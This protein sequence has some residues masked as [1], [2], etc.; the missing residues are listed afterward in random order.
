MQRRRNHSRDQK[1][2]LNKFARFTGIALQ[3]GVTIYAGN[4]LG[5][6]LDQKYNTEN[7]ESIVTLFAVFASMY[8]VIIQVVK[9]SKNS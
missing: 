3:M 7:W 9:A 4:W 2:P 6:W 1:K 8:M 5:K